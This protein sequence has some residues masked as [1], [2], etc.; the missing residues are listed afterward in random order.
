M[1][2]FTIVFLIALLSLSASQKGVAQD[3][4]WAHDQSI[5]QISEHVYRFGSDNQFGAYTVTDEAMKMSVL[6]LM[7]DG[8]PLH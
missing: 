5:E 7:A 8:R 1:S 3:R 4:V 6:E 2:K